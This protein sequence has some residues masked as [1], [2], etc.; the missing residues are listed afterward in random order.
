MNDLYRDIESVFGEVP[1]WLRALPQGAAAAFWSA[2]RDLYLV[3]GGL[4]RKQK[5]LVAL[6]TAAAL[7]DDRAA[8]FHGEVAKLFGATDADL[9]EATAVAGLTAFAATAM[10]GQRLDLDRL[11]E[12]TLRELGHARINSDLGAGAPAPTHAPGHA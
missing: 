9:A 8:L 11:R 5:A 4:P 1:A 2:F 7:H 10:A 3:E 12:H 6:A